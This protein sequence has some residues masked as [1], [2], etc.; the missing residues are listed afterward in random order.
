MHA[1]QPS[2]RHQFAEM[3]QQP[4]PAMDL[5]RASLLIACEEYPELDVP[6]YLGRLDALAAALRVRLEDLRPRAVIAALNR[7][8]FEEEGFQGNTEDYYD[9]RNSFLNDVLDR[10]KGIPITLSAVYMEVGRRAGMDVEGVS[11]PGHFVVRAEGLL[12]DPFHGGT[13]LSTDDCQQRLDRIYGGRLKLV[14]EMLGPCAR[15]DILARM[16]QNLKAIYVKAEDYTRALRV[17]ELLL[18]VHTDGVEDLRDRGLLHAAL[19]CYALAARDLED[20]LERTPGTPE[21][22]QLREK[23]AELRRKAARLN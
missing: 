2:S 4:D 9:P 7:L 20:Y 23:I 18:H 21:A 10:R 11:L 14:P 5:G 16:L 12:V 1:T 8:L 17:V 15:K 6:R 22:P 3:L 19:D 13:I